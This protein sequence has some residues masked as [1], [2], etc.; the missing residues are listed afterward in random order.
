[1]TVNYIETLISR[2]NI[3]STYPALIKRILLDNPEELSRRQALYTQELQTQLPLLAL[4]CKINNQAGIDEKG[5]RYVAAIFQSD[6]AD[7]QVEGQAIVMRPLAFVPERRGTDAADVVSNMFVIGPQDLAAG[8]CLLYRPMLDQPLTQYPSLTNLL[9]AI[10]QSSSLRNS[11]LAWLP[12][13]VR[14]DYERYVFP[15]ELPSPWTVAEFAVDPEKLWAMS[16]PVSLGTQTVSDD[17]FAALFNANANALIGLADRQSVSN[18][19]S[20]WATFKKAGWLIFTLVLPFLGRT[21][22]MA[23]WIWQIVD[24]LQ[25][26]VDAKEHGEKQEQWAALVDVL[27]NLSMAITLHIASRSK[28]GGERNEIEPVTSVTPVKKPTLIKQPP[29][30]SVGERLPAHYQSLHVKGALNR[31]PESLATVLDS[32]ETTKPE[33]LGTASTVIGAHQNLYPLRKHWYA[34]VGQRWFEVTV[35]ENGLVLII[36]PT[37]PD[38]T[39][40]VVIANAKGEWFIDTRLRLRAGGLKSL[41]D[42]AKAQLAQKETLLRTQLG[43]FESEKKSS[44]EQL[45]KTRQDMTEAPGTSAMAKRQLYLQ[46]L[47]T[48]CTDYDAALHKLKALNVLTALPDYQRR[49]LGYIKAQ[50]DL[51]QAGITEALTTFTPKVRTALNQVEAQAQ[52]PQVRHIEDARIMNEVSQDMIDRLDYIQERFVVLKA[53]GKQGLLMI[54]STKKLLPAYSSDDLKALQVMMSRNLCLQ[55][56]TTKTLP[57]AWT[58]IDSI[59]DNA[60]ISIQSLRDTLEERSENR[61]DERI[62]TLSNLYE[63]FNA[64]DERLQDFQQEFPGPVLLEPVARLRRQVKGFNQRAMTHLVILL[65]ERMI[66][67]TR[68]TPHQIAP[69]PTRAFIRTL[70]NGMLIG[71]P[72]LS[73][74]GLETHLV[75]IRSPFTHQILAT[76]HEKI[77]GV[78]VQRVETS[79]PMPVPQDLQTSVN[80]GQALLDGLPAF[81]TRAAE[82]MS[83]SGR[84]PMGVEY[85]FH[86]QALKLERA[87]NA[88]DRSLTDANLT[89]SSSIKAASVNKAL[90]TATQNIYTQ[91]HIKMSNMIKEQ[92]P[93]ASSIEWLN[94]R[95]KIYIKKTVSR[96]R[97]SGISKYQYLDEYTISDRVTH[98][99]LWY[100][101]FQYSTS[102][103]PSKSFITA[104]LKTV[105]EQIRGS[106]A[107]ITEGMN[108]AQQIAFNR[109]EI[110]LEQANRLF[111]AL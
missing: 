19:E 100:A 41:N 69:R 98:K 17:L 84:T 75:D 2:I 106:A 31:T 105:E 77:P 32:F 91:A 64:V 37:L 65:G 51:T 83:R 6:V 34:L 26:L 88:I 12:D 49:S 39:G 96:R 3:G 76:F 59:V 53:F 60:D 92:P 54:Q 27:L 104:R 71:E 107:D 43:S 24:Q 45:Q 94:N 61:L 66:L 11:V 102:W 22:G 103:T 56:D 33:G 5:C 85:L 74:L 36:D 29:D 95:K 79:Q 86:Q 82:Q 97:S 58:A 25:A 93:I 18:T 90:T 109:S 50:L 9:Y 30:I 1:M 16:G 72:R 62:D 47:E 20:R 101:H 67:R 70:Y 81:N 68:A 7:R 46:K 80:A 57:A 48:Q 40:P 87:S 63:Q 89:V 99:V 4:Q 38:R 55:E 13:D 52:S 44:Q 14:S 108:E 78:W 8:P 35:N 10:Q 110:N 42:N 21:V 23:T 73:A 28:L 111:F 15:G